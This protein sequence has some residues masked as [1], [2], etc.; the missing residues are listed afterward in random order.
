MACG[1]ACYQASRVAEDA[2]ETEPPAAEGG[3][4]TAGGG[5]E[6]AILIHGSTP[7]AH[8]VPSRG[9][10]GPGRSPAGDFFPHHFNG[11]PSKVY[12][13]PH[14]H[15]SSSESSQSLRSARQRGKRGQV[16]CK[17]RA[18]KWRGAHAGWVL[19]V[20][21]AGERAGARMW[22]GHARALRP[23]RISG[24][25]VMAMA[26]SISH[27]RAGCDGDGGK[28]VVR[29]AVV[30]LRLKKTVAMVR[31]AKRRG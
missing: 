14:D 24:R 27:F 23:F 30:R 31:A 2:P 20:R 26:A 17:V 19:C 10:V 6:S 25:A 8:P 22:R 15:R 16:L 1:V 5:G 28:V 4:E 9:L 7:W 21:R 3:S 12:V 11:F 13:V 18:R 29:A